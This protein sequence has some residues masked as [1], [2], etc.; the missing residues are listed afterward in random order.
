M[1]TRNLIPLLSAFL[2]LAGCQTT[3]TPAVLS[4]I[5]NVTAEAAWVGVA[6]DLRQHPDHRPALQ[7]TSEALA[8]MIR[9]DTFT[10]ELLTTALNNLPAVH[11]ESG[12]LVEGGAYLFTVAVGFIPLSDAPRLKACVKGLQA[13]VQRALAQ[14][15]VASSRTVP[16]PAKLCDVPPRSQFR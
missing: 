13:G 6:T 3:P 11:G 5:E 8:A 14:P 12:A 10:P 7:V 9:S 4:L 15:V 2:L 1:K 16:L